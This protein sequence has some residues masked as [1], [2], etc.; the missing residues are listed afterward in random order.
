MTKAYEAKIEERAKDFLDALGKAGRVSV[1]I[2]NALGEWGTDNFS[3]EVVKC[4]VS[5]KAKM[6]LKLADRLSK[7]TPEERLMN[8][9][10]A[11]G[12]HE[13]TPND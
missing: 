8:L 6:V 5:S 12:E 11:I 10:A 1:H 9:A 7:T 2:P 13:E 3:P 4:L